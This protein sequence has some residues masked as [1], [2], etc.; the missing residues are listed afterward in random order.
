LNGGLGL[1]QGMPLD[2]SVS[3]DGSE[4]EIFKG[5]VDFYSGYNK[6]SDSEVAVNIKALDDLTSIDARA[7]G[8]TMGL[9]EAEGVL[10]LSDFVDVPY[11]I[12]KPFNL[13]ELALLSLT[14]YNLVK[15]Q[16]DLV[17][18]SIDIITAFTETISIQVVGAGATTSPVAAALGL[19]LRLAALTAASVALSIQLVKLTKDLID[20]ILP[21]TRYH[22]GIYLKT[23]LEKSFGYMGYQFESSISELN[24]LVYVPT[25]EKE[26]PLKKG[27]PGNGAPRAGDAGYRVDGLINETLNMF[28]ADL[29]VHD[30]VVQMESFSNTG[31]WDKTS[32]YVL[33]T[34]LIEDTPF[35][36]NGSESV[37]IN[38]LNQF[39]LIEFKVDD[40]DIWTRRNFTGT[41]SEVH[42]TQITTTE[43]RAVGVKGVEEVKMPFALGNRKDSLTDLEEAIKSLLKLVDSLLNAL[44]GSSQLSEVIENRKGK[45]KIENH[46]IATP[47]LI[48]VNPNLSLPSNHRDLWSAL[49][50]EMKY[51]GQKS[52][53]R[54]NFGGQYTLYENVK[55]PL[56]FRE[57]VE[58]FKSRFFSLDDGRRALF[59][60]NPVWLPELGYGIIS[61]R[62][63]EPW[64]NNLKETFVA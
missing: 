25:K 14:I 53:V 62:V 22:K 55:I 15:Q 60:G 27:Q 23:L 45:L 57:A 43:N 1:T 33:S 58:A 44:G 24:N 5:F 10:S 61:I 37:N 26:G 4:I 6:K 49:V 31:F 12:E 64:T 2:F 21:P 35:Y 40:R 9:L 28:Y 46:E 7:A 34:P 17:R 8:I 51:H 54:N 56:S 48:Y 38:E 63:Q 41:I 50:L 20:R 3:D 52:F 32:N 36:Q 30:G 18:E 42:T 11:L 29:F 39:R 59:D 13:L 16:I 47:K 19:A